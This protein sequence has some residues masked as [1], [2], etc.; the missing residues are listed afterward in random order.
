MTGALAAA[1]RRA[2]I[3]ARPGD[4]HRRRHHRLDAA[5]GRCARAAARARSALERQPRRARVAV[6]GPH[7]RRRGGADHRDRAASTRR[8]TS[9]RS[10]AP[11]RPSGGGRRS[12]TASRSRPTCSTPPPAGSSSPTSFR[13]CSP[14]STTRGRSSAASAPPAT[15]RCTRRRGAACRRRRSSARLDPEARR[16]ARPPLRQGLRP[17][18]SRRRALDRVGARRSACR[19]AS[20]SRWAASTRTTAP[21]APASAPARCQ[22]HRHVHLRL[23]HRA[24]RRRHRRHPRHLRHR[25]RLDH[26]RLL[27]HRG[28]AV[29]GRRHPELVGRGGLPGRRPRCT[30]RCRPRRRRSRRASRGCVALDWNNGNR[31]IL[32]DPRLTGLILGQTLHTTRA[33]IYRALIEATAFGARAIIE[34]MRE[35]GVPIDRVVCCGGIAEK[36]DLFMQ[37]Y[38]DV[39]GQ[40]MLIAGSPQTPALGAADLGRR[41]RR[42]GGGRLRRLDRGAGSDD[43]AQGESG[44][45]RIPPRAPSTMSSMAS[46]ASCTTPSAACPARRA[47]LGTLMKRLLAIKERA[48][49]DESRRACAAIAYDANMELASSGLVMGTFGNLSAADRDAG[50]FAIK[51]SGV[52]YEQLT[53]DAHGRGLARDRGRRSTARC[54]PRPTRRPTSSCIAPS[55]AARSCTR[56]PST[57]RCS[58]RRGCRSAAWGRRTPITSAATSR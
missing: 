56:I 7:L 29:G 43:D 39:I 23:R 10:A 19:R 48:V 38:A 55:A 44:S 57:R 11:T 30:P 46:T 52:P 14:A 26:A 40:P 13:R 37:I 9:R 31:T 51:P 53:P 8:S 12:G 25:Q 41:H 33:E 47:D 18:P 42:R 35:Y 6:E 2:W 27:R 28:G 20:R 15:R 1:A 49:D 45:R 17:G 4:R 36:N 22:D 24:G 34:R 5:A 21:S 58:R 16:A 50:V 3:L 32:V 54:G